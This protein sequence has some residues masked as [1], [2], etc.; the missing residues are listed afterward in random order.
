ML[1]TAL[2]QLLPFLILVLQREPGLAQR[3]ELQ[4]SEPPP[5]EMALL[6]GAKFA[7]L[8]A[9][10]DEQGTVVPAFFIDRTPVTNR[11]FLGF[12]LR[13]PGWRR[14][15]ISS[16]F[17]ESAYLSDWASATSLG[18]ARGD[19]PVV[20]V[21]WFAAKAYCE[22]RQ[23][24]L[25]TDLEWQFAAAASETLP[26][27]R[28]NESFRAM[29]LRFYE[30]PASVP[31]PAVAQ[32]RKNYYGVYDLHGLVWEWVSDFNSLLVSGDSRSTSA[33]DKQTFCGSGALATG[34]NR[35]YAGFMRIAFLSS[36]EASFTTPSLGF[37]CAKDAPGDDS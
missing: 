7:S 11:D 21:S 6:R 17:A 35:D 36:L 1:E 25:P 27:A 15:R 19:A 29:V 13:H 24:R 26:D 9:T 14:D 30:R 37:R 5:A 31:L 34:D 18:A 10:A 4:L 33:A 20:R 32:G 2:S 16:L 23:A 22:S 8:T 3:L 12:V 28:S